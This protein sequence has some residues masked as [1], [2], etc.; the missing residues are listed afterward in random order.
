MREEAEILGL[1]SAAA[2][3][4]TGGALAATLV[5]IGLASGEMLRHLVQAT[6]VLIASLVAWRWPAWGRWAL[7][8]V[9]GFWLFVSLAIWFFLLGLSSPVSGHFNLAERTLAGALGV[10]VLMGFAL[11]PRI[12][13]SV[14]VWSGLA[15]A[16]AFAAL[17]VAAFI[18]STR[19]E[20]A[21][22]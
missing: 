9:F 18:L 2:L 6:P 1:S 3:A 12:R 21:T 5:A 14:G 17:Q 11:Y 22:R 4:V 19:P 13:G 16:A 7:A 20:I 15:G 8:P 10:L